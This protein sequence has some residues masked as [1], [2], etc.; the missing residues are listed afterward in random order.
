[1]MNR[2]QKFDQNPMKNLWELKSQ[3]VKKQIK[4]D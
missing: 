4:F 2:K 3:L 1:M